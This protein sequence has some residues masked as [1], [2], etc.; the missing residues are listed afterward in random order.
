VVVVSG[1]FTEELLRAPEDVL[2]MHEGLNDVGLLCLNLS[3]THLIIVS[4]HEDRVHVGRAHRK[5]SMARQHRSR[6]S[7]RTPIRTVTHT[8]ILYQL[9]R[10]LANILGSVQE[11]L[12][13]AFE[14]ELALEGNGAFLPMSAARY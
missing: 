9:V 1:E 2:S 12:E 5:R 4:D 14:D 7:T 6:I 11:E 13:L 3:R 8:L 10:N